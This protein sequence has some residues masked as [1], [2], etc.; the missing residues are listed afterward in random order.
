MIPTREQIEAVAKL[1]DTKLETED[2]VA[3]KDIFIFMR[4][5]AL[6]KLDNMPFQPGEVV[7]NKRPEFN[8]YEVLVTSGDPD[9]KDRFCGTVIKSDDPGN[10]VGYHSI[11]WVRTY[12]TRKTTNS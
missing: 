4:D 8:K 11:G 9:G 5:A 10:M 3:V 7:I 6:E 12:F 2:R 1:L